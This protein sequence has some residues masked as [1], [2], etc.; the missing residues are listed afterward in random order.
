[1]KGR[2]HSYQSMGTLDGP[3]VRFVVF[4]QGCKLRCG[5]CHNP[6]TWKMGE[7][8][9]VS[10]E[11]VLERALRYKN[12][13]G[14]E[15]GITVSGGEALLQAEFVAELFILCRESGIHTALDT[16]GSVWN[17]EVKRLLHVTDLVLLDIKMTDEEGYQK[18]I[19]CSLKE[20]LFFLDE[21][22]SRKI[23]TWVRQVIVPGLND[24]SENIER[25][26]GLIAGHTCVKKVE[27][28]PFRKLCKE[29]YERM[30]LP[31]PFDRYPEGTAKQVSE[32]Q[33]RVVLPR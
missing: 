16:S 27:L 25:L 11:E 21:L 26:N 15:G 29:K 6:D 33:K 31:F 17:E 2:I 30:E 20:V 32:L 5:Y 23:D 7:G 10:P 1:M 12:Y 28:L 19:G 18:Y 14:T 9:E 4:M 24:R 8:L 13:F 22:Q 3:G